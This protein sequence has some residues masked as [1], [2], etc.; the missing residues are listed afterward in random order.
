MAD[1][2][3]QYHP[4]LDIWN[5]SPVYIYALVNAIV[6]LLAVFGLALDGSQV[7]ALM[8]VVNI[9]L[10]LI[11]NTTPMMPTTIANIKIDEALNTPAPGA[12]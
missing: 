3:T 10:A 4:R 2:N 1:P 8:A 6:A 12:K 7:A 11:Y 5:R 9:L